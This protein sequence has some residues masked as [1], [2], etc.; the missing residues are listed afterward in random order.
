MPC[1]D[2]HDGFS[3]ATVA[4]QIENEDDVI[5]RIAFVG[6]CG[7]DVRTLIYPVP[8]VAADTVNQVHLW[9]H[10]CIVEHV[11]AER[12]LVMG[13]GVSSIVDVV[14]AAVTKLQPGDHIVVEPG[15]ACRRSCDRAARSNP[16]S[17]LTETC[18]T[19]LSSTALTGTEAKKTAK[20]SRK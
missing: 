8:T 4:L 18:R 14:G 2:R 12:P 7:I 13:H 11:S 3:S 6:F 5:L 10:G 9:T 1:P 19:S 17:N 15:Y 20:A 16:L